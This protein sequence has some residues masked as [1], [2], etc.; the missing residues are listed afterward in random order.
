MQLRTC[1]PVTVGVYHCYDYQVLDDT[2]NWW[3]LR[4]QRGEEGHAP[5]TILQPYQDSV[6]S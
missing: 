6:R 3:K 2:R 1:M 5:Y 4:N